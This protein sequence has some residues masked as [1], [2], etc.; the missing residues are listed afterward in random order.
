MKRETI[1]VI[2]QKFNETKKE[3]KPLI[4]AVGHKALTVLVRQK[5]K[6]EDTIWACQE[7]GFLPNVDAFYG[8]FFER[9][10]PSNALK[11]VQ[12]FLDLDTIESIEFEIFDDEPPT[13]IRCPDCGMEGILNA[14]DE[15][16]CAHDQCSNYGGTF[17]A[18]S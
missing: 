17:E 4:D 11:Q 16:V 13:D 10:G 7:I 8:K 3:L 18:S 5:G 14:Q 6:A 15:R 1:E 2:V 12:V 9:R